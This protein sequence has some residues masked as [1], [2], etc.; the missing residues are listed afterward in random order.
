MRENNLYVYLLIFVFINAK[1]ITIQ[2]LT[3]FNIYPD[4]WDYI[5]Y[6]YILLLYFRNRHLKIF[7]HVTPSRPLLNAD[8]T[9]EKNVSQIVFRH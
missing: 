4:F 7:F 3:S 2:G 6:I 9:L 8:H 1:N 5:I